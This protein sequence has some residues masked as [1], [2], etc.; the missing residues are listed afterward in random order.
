MIKHLHE[1]S[2]VLVDWGRCSVSPTSSVKGCLA[3]TV[4][5]C[6]LGSLSGGADSHFLACHRTVGV[7]AEPSSTAGEVV[8]LSVGISNPWFYHNHIAK[9]YS[10]AS[11]V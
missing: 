3:I 4:G 7:V 6:L 5:V 2:N 1:K 11:L 9:Q 10:I 8:Q